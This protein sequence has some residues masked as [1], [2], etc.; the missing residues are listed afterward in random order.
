MRKDPKHM[1]ILCKVSNQPANGWDPKT[2]GLDFVEDEQ[3]SMSSI[4]LGK[5][6]AQNATSL[7]AP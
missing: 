7:P 4:P 1:R 5:P 2:R 6:L 3:S